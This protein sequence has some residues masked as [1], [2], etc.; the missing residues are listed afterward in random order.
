MQANTCTELTNPHQLKLAE[1]KLISCVYKTENHIQHQFSTQFKLSA[2]NS[3]KQCHQ[4]H[5]HPI[6]PLQW[7]LKFKLI[8]V[9][10][11]MYI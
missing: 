3:T 10:D 9:Y 11:Y 1:G 5:R 4:L 2:Y 8:T 7:N 6:Q